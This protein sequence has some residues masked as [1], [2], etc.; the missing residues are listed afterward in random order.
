MK[1]KNYMKYYLLT[2]ICFFVC[3]YGVAEQKNPKMKKMIEESLQTIESSENWKTNKGK[4]VEALKIISQEGV[5][6]A[7]P[8]LIPNVSFTPVDTPDFTMGN[9]D[10]VYPVVTCLK[11]LGEAST[12]G[13]IVYVVDSKHPL[14]EPMVMNLKRVLI[15]VEGLE[16][17]HNIISD[18]IK[19]EAAAEKQNRLKVLLPDLTE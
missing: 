6:N 18:A 12:Q 16:G 3:C 17:A 9:I 15:G 2:V 4:I 5:T 13:I 11:E 8:I 10:R 1:R 19:K 7:I 14:T